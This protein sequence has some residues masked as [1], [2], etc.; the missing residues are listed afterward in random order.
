[1]LVSFLV[2]HKYIVDHLSNPFTFYDH[3]DRYLIIV[4]DIWQKSIWER[5]KCALVDSNCGSRVITTTRIHNVAKEVGDVYPM[6]KLSDENSKRL[7]DKRVL[8]TEYRSVSSNQSE[9]VTKKILKKCDGV[10]LSIIT[11]ASVLV[12]KDD[13]SEVYDSVGFGPEDGNEVVH[14]TKKILSFSYYDLPSYLQ[15]CLLY[16]SIYPEDDSIEKDCLIWK[17]IAEGFVY[18]KQGKQLFEVGETYFNELINRSMVQPIEGQINLFTVEGCRINDTMLYLIRDLSM[19]VDFVKILD[20]ACEEHDYCLQSSTIHRIA[21]HHGMRQDQNNNIAL[22]MAR[23]R[24][25]NAIGCPISM[26]PPVESFQA[27]RVLAIEYCDVSTR[28]CQLKYLGKLCQLR[29]LGLTN[30]PVVELPR[31]IG[32]LVHLQTLDVRDTG[33]EELPA[34]VGKLSKL[35]RLCTGED[36]RLPFGVGNMTSLQELSLFTLTADCCPNFSVELRK[37]T[38]LRVLRILE[39]GNI[40]SSSLKTLVESFC[41]LR[42]IQQLKLFFSS[43]LGIT[44]LEGWEPPLQLRIFSIPG[45][46]IARLPAWGNCKHI[47]NLCFTVLKLETWD[48]EILAKMPELRY[49]IIYIVGRFS[50]TIAGGGL[51]PSL[52]DFTTDITVTFLEGAMPMLTEIYLKLQVS[53]GD[54][55]K[56]VGLGNLLQLNTVNFDLRCRGATRREVKEAEV[57]ARRMVDG[58]PNCPRI[59]I[60]KEEEV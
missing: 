21:V 39:V 36:T 57:A 43:H 31:E 12:H 5:I 29:Y 14:N 40:N 4:D 47:S 60:N 33:L 42:R 9:E 19:E 8:G 35:M 59:H 52:R 25:L 27:L 10:P 11:I 44:S 41:S 49:L 24:S 45:I 28:G 2:R 30:T 16:L 50:W 37:L 54:A 58:H 6:E 7:F 18:E 38:N 17:W 53:T 15:R 1:M 46:S 51:F 48:L 56:H 20:R 34:T 13:W 3:M 32:D 26:L 55:A 23:L 22:R